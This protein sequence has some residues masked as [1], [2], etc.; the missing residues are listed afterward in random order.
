[1]PRIDA[2][3]DLF[4][5]EIDRRQ[6]WARGVARAKRALGWR[7]P[8]QAAVYDATFRSDAEALSYN[9]A[10]RN[11]HL[12][13]LENPVWLNEKIRWQFLHHCNP[14]MS[15]AADKI[16]VRD[17]LRFKRAVVYV[18][19]VLASGD[20]PSDLLGLDLPER[21]V[22]KSSYGSGQ[23]HIEDGR[24]PT[25]RAELARKATVWSEYD[26]WRST[27]E[28]HYRAIPKRWLVEEFVPATQQKLEYKVFCM[29][30]EPVFILVITERTAA[31]YKRALYD[32]NWRRLTFA[33]RGLVDD[34]RPVPRPDDLALV[35][36]EARRL[37]EDFLHVRVDFLKFDGRLVFS[38]LTFASLAARVPYEPVGI[39]SELGALMDL[40]QAPDRLARG[41]RIAAELDWRPAA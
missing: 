41:R 40:A 19:E 1:M 35:L 24:A 26:Q 6:H 32:V 9:Y 17:Y 28:F 7:K 21:F 8:M 2:D 3:R 22:L 39:N 13:D 31:G 12:P 15:L 4:I 20:D 10:R 5:A 25:P 36:D 18:P 37:S 14:L 30:G 11:D 38:E 34:S 29:Q 16:A 33:A 23:N 27:G